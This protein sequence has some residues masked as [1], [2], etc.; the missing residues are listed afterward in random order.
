MKRMPRI[1][2]SAGAVFAL[3]GSAFAA[4]Q[5]VGRERPP[6][7]AVVTISSTAPL[8]AATGLVGGE[9]LERCTVLRNE[10]PQPA[11]VTLFGTAAVNDLSPWLD[12]ELVRGSLPSGTPS[13]DCTGFAA[14]GADYGVGT[15]GVVFRGTLASLPD[16]TSGIADPSRWA[17]GEEHA[18]LIRVT[19]TGANPQQGMQTI[20]DFNW[21]VTPFDDRPPES[22]TDPSATPTGTA[23]PAPGS[24]GGG[25]AAPAQRQCKVVSFGPG[26]PYIGA[27]ATIKAKAVS[28]S[29][30]KRK[31]AARKAALAPLG[32]A[33]AEVVADGEQLTGLSTAEVRRR[34]ELLTATRRLGA[35]RSPVMVVRITKSKGDTLSLRVALRKNGKTQSPRRWRW[36]RMRLNATAT[37]ST[38]RWPFVSTA[39][40][41]QLRTG[42]NQIDLTLNRGR[43]GARIKGYPRL[44]RRSFAFVVK[45]TDGS[46]DCVLG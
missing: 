2:A 40:M 20:Q 11:D 42:Y 44:V 32:I 26:R 45:A 39:K 1:L 8:F 23:T 31:A 24:A 36:V 29:K 16:G 15:P 13:G 35:R 41:G 19:Y 9:Q 43:K 7:A 38:V 25:S 4:Q 37:K 33:P 46:S 21:G 28:S 5:L 10:G 22:F 14:D 6:A 27:R 17:V 34:G 3:A 30:R 18:Y 12:V